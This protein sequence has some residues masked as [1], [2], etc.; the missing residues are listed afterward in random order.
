MTYDKKVTSGTTS[1]KLNNIVTQKISRPK[2]LFLLFW[3]DESGD[4]R[5]SIFEEACLTRYFNILYSPEYKKETQIVYHLSINTFNQIKEILE[6]FINKNGGITK[7]KVKEV[8]LF[9][10]GGP[11]H[12]PTTS[13]SVNTPSVPKYPQ[14]MDIIGGWD[15]IDFNWSNNAMFVMYGCRTSYASDDSGQGFA[16]KLSLLDNFKDVNVWGQTESTYP[17]YFPDIR[18]T[19]IMRSINIGWS[20]SPTY[21][22]ASS[23]GQG[24][25]ALFPDDKN[26]LKSLPMQCYNNGKLILTC[27][28]SSFNDHRKN[29]SN[30]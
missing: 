15:S 19:S 23:E 10:H 29:K 7:A 20:F 6:I 4:S 13:D 12:G 26:P 3:V 24:W 2:E 30:D 16:S 9:S 28:Q 14:Q 8:S 21:M 25:D 5:R 11:I 1:Q 17:S 18:T 27:D 22:V